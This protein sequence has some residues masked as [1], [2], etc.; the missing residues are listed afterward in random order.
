MTNISIKPIDDDFYIG[1]VLSI[2]NCR[3]WFDLGVQDDMS[4]WKL[5]NSSI[6]LPHMILLTNYS[7]SCIGG[8]PLLAKLLK[9]Q[10][11]EG[12]I[13][14]IPIICTEPVFRFGRVILYDMINHINLRDRD[15]GFQFT[16]SAKN[17]DFLESPYTEDDIDCIM[18][19]NI[20]RLRYYQSFEIQFISS[21]N[22]KG[23]SDLK[24]ISLKALPSGIDMG[25]TMWYLTLNT[26]NGSWDILYAN[27]ITSSPYWH[28]TPADICR[29]N[30]PDIFITSMLPIHIEKSVLTKSL[31]TYEQSNRWK[32]IKNFIHT[33]LCC[34]KRNQTGSILIPIDFDS[35][36]LELLCYIDAVWN[37]SVILYP[38]VVVSPMSS[39]FILSAKTLIEWMSLDIRSE[40]CNTRFN[41]FHGLKNILIEN[42][43][44]NV[45]TGPSAKLP[46]VIFA[47]PASMDYGYSRELFAELASNPNNSV[48]FTK[49]PKLNT[50]AHKVWLERK[51]IINKVPKGFKEDLG[52]TKLELPIIRFIPYRQDELY[53]LY[54]SQ[55][56]SKQPNSI[57]SIKDTENDKSNSEFSDIQVTPK[58]E[59][60]NF[61]QDK[62]SLLE[63]ME[64]LARVGSGVPGKETIE[65]IQQSGTNLSNYKGSVIG[66][67]SSLGNAKQSVLPNLTNFRPNLFINSKIEELR[68]TLVPIQIEDDLDTPNQ[69]IDLDNHLDTKDLESAFYKNTNL[70]QAKDEYGSFIDE[71][72]IRNIAES[73]NEASSQ[74]IINLNEINTIKDT[75]N[76]SYE[77][78]I[79][80]THSIEVLASKRRRD[81]LNINETDISLLPNSSGTACN[82]SKVQ[83]IITVCSTNNVGNRN[84]VSLSQ[85]SAQNSTVLPEW[86]L[87]LRQILGGPE[88]FKTKYEILNIEVQCQFFVMNGLYV[89]DDIMSLVPLINSCSPRNV[90][91]FP[92]GRFLLSKVPIDIE[93]SFGAIK[94]LLLSIPNTPENIITMDNIE[95]TIELNLVRNT[96]DIQLSRGIWDELSTGGFQFIPIAPSPS[97]GIAS[98]NESDLLSSFAAIGRV[99]NLNLSFV[100]ESNEMLDSNN[101]EK[102]CLVRKDENIFKN[103]DNEKSTCQEFNSNFSEVTN[104]EVTPYGFLSKLIEQNKRF[105]FD[106]TNID[107]DEIFVSKS[108]GL[109]H[110]VSEM[111]KQVPLPFVYFAPQGGSVC[112][113]Q[114]VALASS[115]Q[116][117]DSNE[118]SPTY[119]KDI[120]IQKGK[121]KASEFL[122]DTNIWDIHATIHPYYYIARNILKNQFAAL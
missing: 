70:P 67:I 121:Y 82:N 4:L 28:V 39:S 17:E 15:N 88:P 90:I 97:A 50:F 86:R 5:L 61:S 105:K 41:P 52:H 38:I 101:V 7:I 104:N 89:A 66:A 57:D 65:S 92:Q 35:L 12:D 24:S 22:N 118:K 58:V 64:F 23:N 63:Y 10:R 74:D 108:R 84:S 71:A 6:E 19:D 60:S 73:W 83:T 46:K 36:L 62:T 59:E 14:N 3:I 93:T 116:A 25:S 98:E 120:N 45:R 112:I 26:S 99:K 34:F 111:K 16:C 72:I 1:K 80:M 48:I 44:N 49:E 30:C 100:S 54:L 94:S 95:Q 122:C 43:L 55:K 91:L 56:E 85:N 115:N 68:S 113:H 18:G 107:T 32:A 79:D 9:Q 29:V 53:A 96:K 8:L 33:I 106:I 11:F 109:R 13:V 76:L 40:F 110:F 37:R 103:E 102:I 42:T 2:S 77:H 69:I 78:G 114:V 51:E 119:S 47:S 27:Q 81:I 21:A 31:V 87:H 117:S 20:C 75:Q